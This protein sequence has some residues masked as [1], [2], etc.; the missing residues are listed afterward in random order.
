MATQKDQERQEDLD[1][2]W[3]VWS[4]IFSILALATMG[5]ATLFSVSMG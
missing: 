3:W 2:D 4:V 5:L 1:S